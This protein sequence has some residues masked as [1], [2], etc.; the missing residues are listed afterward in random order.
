MSYDIETAGLRGESFA[1]VARR[2]GSIDGVAIA[3]D[4]TDQEV[5]DAVAENAIDTLTFVSAYGNG[6]ARLGRNGTPVTGADVTANSTFLIN[7]PLASD[8][9]QFLYQLDIFAKTAGNIGIVAYRLEGGSFYRRSAIY[10]VALEAGVNSLRTAAGQLPLIV[11][12]RGDYLGITNNVGSP[13][14]LAA[15]AAI[16]DNNGWA[17]SAGSPD[18]FAAS[19]TTG[20]RLQWSFKVAVVHGVSARQL[21]G[22]YVVQPSTV[23][24][25]VTYGQSNSVGSDALPALTTTP[26]TVHY[27]FNVSPKMTGPSLAGGLIPDDGAVKFLVEDE[28]APAAGTAGE[29]HL[30]SAVR[31]VTTRMA[32]RGAGF[33]RWFAS[34][35]GSPGA[36]ITGIDQTSAFYT[37]NFLYHVAHANSEMAAVGFAETLPVVTFDHGETD[38]AASMTKATYLA[39]ARDFFDAASAAIMAATG[40]DYRP[41]FLVTVPPYEIKTSDGPTEALIQLSKDRDDVHFVA[42][43]YRMPYVNNV[44]LSNVGQILKGHYYGRAIDQLLQ[45]RRPDCVEWLGAYAVGTKLIVT[46]RAPTAMQF[47]GGILPAATDKGVV[48][49]D[50]T[51][52]LTLS[53]M[54]W[55][56]A[57]VDEATGWPVSRLSITLNRVLGNNPFFR[58]AKDVLGSGMGIQNGASGNICDGTSEI[59]TISG[60][61]YVMAHFAPPATLAIGKLE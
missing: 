34:A 33:Q 11:L 30:S 6:R 41:H 8:D 18:S 50:D 37:N 15:T 26:S 45:G 1:D 5:L 14:T 21:L 31:D 47:D 55:S 48:V 58:Y 40:Q 16:S 25:L 43:G 49:K 27:T 24:H 32:A 23:M 42:P 46:A 7:T 44:H 51:G 38:Q 20:F 36:G 57:G 52:T 12:K 54:A 22:D 61:D 39:K 28:L 2:V 60:T 10:E 4:A 9:P 53:G 59:V 17:S 56:S 19:V 35:A 3:A 13:A 29:T